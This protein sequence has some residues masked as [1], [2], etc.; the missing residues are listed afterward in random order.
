MQ[1]DVI[2]FF[3]KEEFFW[4][5]NTLE[6]KI[7][8]VGLGLMRQQDVA[9]RGGLEPKVIMFSKYVLNCGDAVKKLM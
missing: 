6:W 4:D 1:Y 3:Q 2:K 7:R 8:S 5:K 9:K